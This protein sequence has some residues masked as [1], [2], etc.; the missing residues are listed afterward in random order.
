MTEHVDA[1]ERYM[2]SYLTPEQEATIDA[3]RGPNA[4]TTETGRDPDEED[5]QEQE[6]EA[7][8]QRRSV[9]SQEAARAAEY[10]AARAKTV[11]ADK[12]LS[13]TLVAMDIARAELVT[14]DDL[15]TVA[16]TSSP[17]FNKQLVADAK[18]HVDLAKDVI[19]SPTIQQTIASLEAE[20]AP[21]M[22]AASEVAGI[23]AEVEV[24]AEEAQTQEIKTEVQAE[25]VKAAEVKAEELKTEEPL[26]EVG[27]VLLQAQMIRQAI[28][29]NPSR[30]LT[31]TRNQTAIHEQSKRPRSL[32]EGHA[33]EFSLRKIA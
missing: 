21:S 10:D 1:R 29:E 28:N 2:D 32:V 25:E 15:L 14:A 5:D 19:T 9:E 4:S 30:A 16:A 31:A 11:E 20:K 22:T 3:T 8:A 26:T 27:L 6:R 12:Q 24:K 13:E 7:A 33:R 18:R 17:E 23:M